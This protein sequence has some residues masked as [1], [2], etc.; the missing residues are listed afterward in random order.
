MLAVKL[1]ILCMC[2]MVTI[3]LT[4]SGRSI[5]IYYIHIN[6]ITLTCLILLQYLAFCVYKRIMYPC[7]IENTL[8]TVHGHVHLS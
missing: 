5:A 7:V 8:R 4:T 6:Q 3:M 2:M 1:L